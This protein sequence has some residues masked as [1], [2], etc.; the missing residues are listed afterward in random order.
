[1]TFRAAGERAASALSSV[2]SG[3]GAVL[4]VG[5][6]ASSMAGPGPPGGLVNGDA[7]AAPASSSAAEGSATPVTL[8]YTRFSWLGWKDT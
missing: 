2:G 4:G 1:M 6:G 5:V 8:K 3:A 7:G